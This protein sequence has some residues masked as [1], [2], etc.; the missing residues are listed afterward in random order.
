[1]VPFYEN[2]TGD[3]HVSRL[4][5]L[6][7]LPHLHAQLELLYV[8]DGEIEITVNGLT[9][10]LKS[11]DL[12]VS[13]P[14]SVHS[15]HTPDRPAGMHCILVIINLSLTGDFSHTLMKYHP[16]EPFLYRDQ[17]HRDVPYAIYTLME[18]WGGVTDRSVCPPVCKA[19]AQMIISRLFQQ[20]ELIAN[21]DAN[22]FDILYQI[23]S[24]INENFMQPLSLQRLS[25][26]L[27]VGRYR[28]S[29]IFSDKINVRFSDYVN[30][31]RVYRACSL[32]LGTNKNITQ[33]AY[34]CGFQ[35]AR[36]FDRAFHK[37]Y[38]LS[39]REY[40]DAQGT[41]ELPHE[42]APPGGN[43]AAQREK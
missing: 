34:D 8:E 16:P 24:F 39:P 35:S 3:L 26:A 20:M 9:R 22:Y 30:G 10:L 14:N 23:I 41:N 33:I 29:R 4:E 32:L 17:L 42:G 15:Y 1:M 7:F 27:G 11:G 25:K 6:N 40:R 28:V 19:Y 38:G 18:E 12:A 43:S 13:F 37:A 31:I 5:N 2:R 21:T 36:T